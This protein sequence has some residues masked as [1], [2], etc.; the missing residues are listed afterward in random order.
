VKKS[1]GTQLMS[2]G[3]VMSIGRSFLG[4]CTA[5][6][7]FAL[8]DKWAI[9]PCVKQVDTLAAEFPAQTN[10]LYL[11]FTAETVIGRLARVAGIRLSY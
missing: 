3:E 11:T 7:I 5:M 6:D 9:K 8:R 1:L 4:R 2:V 10:Y